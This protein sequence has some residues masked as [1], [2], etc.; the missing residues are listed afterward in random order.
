M[1]VLLYEGEFMEGKRYMK[2]SFWMEKKVEKEKNIMMMEIYYS[3]E[4]L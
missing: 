3:K 2:K 1:G 4:N